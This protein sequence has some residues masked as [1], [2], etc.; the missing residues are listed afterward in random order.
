LS[1][2]LEAKVLRV[3]RSDLR[4]GL[5]LFCLLTCLY[6][7]TGGAHTAIA[8]EETVYLVTEGLVERGTLAQLEE[9][10]AGNAPRIV[11]RGRDGRLYAITGPLQSLLAVPLY[12]VGK[13]VAR[14]F[15]PPFYGYF[16]RFFVCLFNS[17]VG[18]A[19]VAL[20]YLFG[21]D[22]GYRR[23]TA[24]F[25]ALTYGLAT[26]AWPYARTFFA[27]TLHVFWLTLAAWAVYRY[28]RTDRW[29]WM[30]LGGTTMGLGVATKY[31]VAV[32][33]P[34]FALYL[35]LEFW[36]RPDRRAHWRWAGRT[37]F[38]G[39][40]PFALIVCLLLVFNYVRFGSLWE[41][42]YTASD[43]R[44]AV[45]KWLAPATSVLESLYGFL[46]SSGKGFF[47]FSPPAVLS[48]CGLTALARRRRN[49]AW[50]FVAI[51]AVYPLFY[52]LLQYRGAPVWHGGGNWGP[53]YVVC[54]TPFVVLS[55]G[56]FLERRDVARCWRVGAATSLFVVGFWVQMS[57]AFVSYST[58]LF[59]DVPSDRQLFHPA[60]STLLAQWRLWP[61]QM[62]AWRQYDHALRTSGE[63][64]YV[65]AGSFYDV[66]VP[67]MAPFGRWMGEGGLLR[68]YA[69]PAQALTIRLAYSR[70]RAA[71]VEGPCWSGPRFFYDGAA[72]ASEQRLTAESERETR[73]VETLTIAA[74]SVH[75]F[76]ATLELTATTWVPLESGDPR[77][78]SI[79]VERVEVLSDGAPLMVCEANLPR[80]LPVSTAY[81]WSWEAMFWF[82]DPENARPCDLWAWYVWTSGVPLRQAQTFIVVFAL[83]LGGASIASAI[84]LISILRRGL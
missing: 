48:L 12:V 1:K 8:D 11:T 57:T 4:T 59:S 16:T 72:V 66:E 53:R 52:S 49:E 63:Q 22:L 25:V 13:W 15:P 78:L 47:F 68:I 46:F 23:R 10:Q 27:E 14:A 73:W 82:Y 43:M 69:R 29:G 61:R 84:W 50:L 9:A 40:L 74:D 60:D 62:A 35:L 71:D 70:P 83:A 76:P 64:F 55:I 45:A 80:P 65:I 51:A 24:L 75:I 33:G 38:A 36:R 31:A 26:V 56:A 58:Y 79:F 39:G 54:I 19:T 17:P 20:L 6:A 7:L 21:V 77:E 81:S 28:A 67:D 3:N 32:A 42:G 5:A 44:G 2:P 41:T 18:A 37:L 34:V 30:A